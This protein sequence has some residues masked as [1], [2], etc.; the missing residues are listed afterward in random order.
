MNTINKNRFEGSLVVLSLILGG[1][2]SSQYYFSKP[3]FSQQQYDRDKFECLQAAQQPMLLTPT[4]GMPTGGM[5]TNKDIYFACFRAKGYTV[6]SEEE[7]NRIMR[8][9]ERAYQEQLQQRARERQLREEAAQ[10]E[11]LA[12]MRRVQ[13]EKIQ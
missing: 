1:C 5:A 13:A 8:A 10:K 3:D 11:R 7:R 6:Q 12:E 2:G 9:E 4:P